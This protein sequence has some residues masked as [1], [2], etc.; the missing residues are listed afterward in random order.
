M[1]FSS[2]YIY[3]REYFGSGHFFFLRQI[4]FSCLSSFVFYFFSKISFTFIKRFF[5]I[6][7][8]G[9]TAL[10]FLTFLFPHAQKGSFRWLHFQGY[11]LQPGE[12][13]KLTSILGL[14]W[15]LEKKRHIIFWFI[16]IIPFLLLLKQPDF[17][18]FVLCLITIFVYLFLY[19]FSL[20]K[21]IYALLCCL[22]FLFYLVIKEPYRLNRI[23]SFLNPWKDPL[24][25][26]FQVIQSF[27]AFAKGGLFGVGLGNSYEKL[28][29][30]PEAHNDFLFS[31][32]GEEL[33]FLG[34][35]L[36]VT[37]YYLFFFLL[38]KHLSSSSEPI[39]GFTLLFTLVFQAFVNISV[40]L[41]ILPTKGITLPFFSYGGSSLL[42][43]SMI[44]GILYGLCKKT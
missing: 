37:L 32:L 7:H 1:I 12:F 33:G 23:L 3:A 17:G 42:V 24:G 15:L 25:K 41:G 22:P 19:K 43:S 26:G 44:L 38:N 14:Y 11:S 21:T 5:F 31:V 27:L 36:F 28:F 34:V 16:Y 4:I 29:Y 18:T 39:L 35:S 9:V 13:L 30:L 20:K 40:C 10:L 8:I 6:S 2:S